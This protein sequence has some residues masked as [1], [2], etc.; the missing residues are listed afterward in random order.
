MAIHNSE[1]HYKTEA[2]SAQI[3]YMA[4]DRCR[5]MVHV[6]NDQHIVQVNKL[7]YIKN[8]CLTRITRKDLFLL[9]NFSDTQS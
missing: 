8:K 1:V 4:V 7:K 9:K 3:L 2:I 6:T 5:D